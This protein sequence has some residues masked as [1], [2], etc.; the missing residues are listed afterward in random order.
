MERKKITDIP[1]DAAL[2]KMI[3]GELS[4]LIE[5][6]RDLHAHP[7]VAFE[8]TYASKVIQDELTRLKIPFEA[9]LGKTG[10]VAWIMPADSQAA[11]NDAVALRADMDAL[12]ITEENDL[13]YKSTYDGFMHACGHDG[14]VA[15]L[16]GAAR[17]LVSL[18]DSLP[19]PVKLFFQ[20]A[21]ET[22]PD[23]TVRGA[24]KLVESGALDERTGGIRVA[25]V[26]ALHGWPQRKLG[27][28]TTRPGA[29]FAS[30]DMFRITITGRGGH[31]AAPHLT[32][33]PIPA[34]VQTVT[35]LQTIVSRNVSPTT[36]AVLTVATLHAGTAPNIIPHKAV[37]S[38]TLRALDESVRTSIHQRLKEIATQTAAAMG[39]SAE[40]DIISGCPVT[41][42]DPQATAGALDIARRTL[43][44]ECVSLLDNPIMV[45]EDFAIYCQ[46]VPGCLILL[47]TCPPQCD[48]YPMLHT[49]QYNFNDD[50]IP[51]GVALFCR[52]TTNDR[53]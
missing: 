8:E 35:A 49:P 45:A 52:L 40:I 11:G 36:P 2:G 14:H 41:I 20:P 53:A 44:E 9:G 37:I 21:E 24:E 34:A 13:P 4:S 48:D 23:V 29:F 38:G 22:V 39:C 5:L 28:V 15:M 17:I 26:F 46:N 12:A 50:A 3:E 6:R 19:Q 31:G 27:H 30:S 7:Q 25:R 18:R 1:D 10:V 33:D 16:L 42:N 51:Y 47:G 43:G 32:T